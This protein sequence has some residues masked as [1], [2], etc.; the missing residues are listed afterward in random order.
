MLKLYARM[1]RGLVS[2]LPHSEKGLTRTT[3]INIGRN[4]SKSERLALCAENM[5]DSDMILFFE[6]FSTHM[7]ECTNDM[8]NLLGANGLAQE[9]DLL[10]IES[11]V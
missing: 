1:T 9:M 7:G 6:S 3:M 4:P 2:P 8:S 11:F 10:K 5:H